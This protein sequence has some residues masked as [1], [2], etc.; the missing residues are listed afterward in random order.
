M[1]NLG[2]SSCSKFMLHILLSY[3]FTLSISLFL[4][5]CGGDS[6]DAEGNS[7]DNAV[8]VTA[9]VATVAA[10]IAAIAVATIVSV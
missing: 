9:S 2:M 1:F 7:S 3:S 5:Q 10:A 8:T 6:G 4:Q